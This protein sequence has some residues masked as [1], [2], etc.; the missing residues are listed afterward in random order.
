MP[1][2]AVYRGEALIELVPLDGR[3]VR[4]GR[5]PENDLVL[6]DDG[7][8]VSRQHAEIRY[9]NGTYIVVDL[10]APNG[11]WIDGKRITRATLVAGREVVVGPYRLVM[12]EGEASTEDSQGIPGTMVAPGP[13]PPADP[14]SERGQTR[15]VPVQGPP[16]G[17]S[18]TRKAAAST[19]MLTAL[20]QQPTILFLGGGGALATLIL[21]AVLW[22][23]PAG[24]EEPPKPVEPPPTVVSTP[25]PTIDPTLEQIA[26]RLTTARTML[27]AKEFDNAL[28][29]LDA[30]FAL[31][32][33]NA[34]A[35][36]LREQVISARELARNTPR[37]PAVRK[38]TPTP[39]PI[40]GE[41]YWL[42][43]LEGESDTDWRDRNL[44]IK[45]E[46]D[47]AIELLT[48][49]EWVEA[50]RALADISSKHGGYLDTTSSLI[51]AREGK[52]DQGQAA[53]AAAHVEE[54]GDNLPGA[55]RALL[56]AIDYGDAEAAR[57]LKDLDARMAAQAKTALSNA[58]Q[59]DSR[60]RVK[61][62]MEQFQIVV[63]YLPAGNPDR[64]YAEAAL[65]RLRQRAP[66]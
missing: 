6:V 19:G 26:Q 9:Q 52:R 14:E 54:K 57:L 60:D 24:E 50:E 53:V 59:Y 37:D 34:D 13:R 56:R 61:Q 65:K 51:R 40:V 32:A 1:T 44:R 2:L 42:A 43:K 66:Q 25:K 30:V 20:K 5:A 8:A 15:P 12:R 55:R 18:G 17:T 22:Q 64:E 4:I 11:T 49:Q 38:P 10:K 48:K 46:Y 27:E 35:T 16:T 63:D 45:A 47:Q 41:A 58:K 36:Q 28:A 23:M 29:E 62:A 21:V 3:N 39:P 7:K 31:D 33:A